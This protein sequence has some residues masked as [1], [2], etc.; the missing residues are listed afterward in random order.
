MSEVA[1]NLKDALKASGLELP[2]RVSLF[3][4]REDGGRRGNWEVMSRDM[5][6]HEVDYVFKKLQQY[7]ANFFTH[8]VF[9]PTCGVNPLV[10]N[11]TAAEVM[12]GKDKWDL[13]ECSRWYETLKPFTDPALCD[14][15]TIFCGDDA[16]STRNEAFHDYMLPAFVLGFDQFTQVA[17]MFNIASEA[18]KTMGVDLQTRMIRRMRQY[19]KLPI[20]AQNQG[21]NISPEADGLMY[22]SRNHPLKGDQVSVADMVNEI[23]WVLKN[24]GKYVIVHEIN[25]NPEGDRCREQCRALWAL[26]ETEPRLI[27]LPVPV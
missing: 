9:S 1:I 19:T 3:T 20:V 5:P 18:G 25:L 16:D 12:R 24:Y 15:P 22:E 13:A 6:Q 8:Y 7:N 4:N 10:G 26:A 11:P 2:L 27:G 17:K 21:V 14:C 23:K